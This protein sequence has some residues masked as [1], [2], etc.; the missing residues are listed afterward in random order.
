MSLLA[1]VCLWREWMTAVLMHCCFRLLSP[2][3]DRE[4][5]RLSADVAVMDV[6]PCNCDKGKLN[7][8]AVS[9]SFMFQPV[10]R[11]RQLQPV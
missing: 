11:F 4:I 6:V 7:P 5:D 10:L 2:I 8:F 9:I 1:P 3:R